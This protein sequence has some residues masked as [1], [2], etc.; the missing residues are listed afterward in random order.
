MRC[1]W[2]PSLQ[3]FYSALFRNTR[4]IDWSGGA[5]P[6]KPGL[7]CHHANY[8]GQGKSKRH[9]G[10]ADNHFG[11]ADTVKK[12]R[13]ILKDKMTARHRISH[14][15]VSIIGTWNFDIVWN[16]SIEFWDFRRFFNLPPSG[17][18]PPGMYPW[19]LQCN[20]RVRLRA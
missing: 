1:L 16:L 12:G 10:G 6:G 2:V 15:Y 8:A 19:P 7:F 11:W 17:Y 14:R 13:F 5:D 4:A 3:P 9:S 18:T 20:P